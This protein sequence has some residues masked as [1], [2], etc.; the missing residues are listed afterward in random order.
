[1]L[2]LA[3]AAF[4][5][6]AAPFCLSWFFVWRFVLGLSGSA[7]MVLAGYLADRIGFGPA[8]RF[9]FLVQA[10]AVGLLI[11]SSASG[12]LIMSSFVIGAFVP[13]IVPLVLA[14]GLAVASLGNGDIAS[15]RLTSLDLR[16]VPRPSTSP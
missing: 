7:L 16:N 12:S 15:T 5:T 9:A 13:G 2:A 4:F 1:M 8:L 6:C 10:V 14:I 11:V 3:T